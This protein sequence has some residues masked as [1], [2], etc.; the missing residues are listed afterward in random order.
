MLD[1]F[2]DFTAEDIGQP[3]MALQ[4]IFAAITERPPRAHAKDLVYGPN[5]IDTP[6]VGEGRT[7]RRAFAGMLRSRCPDVPLILEHLRPTDIARCKA[8][9]E[10]AFI[11]G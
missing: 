9:V 8:L 7:D 11:G 10:Q 1:P 2:N 6:K 4:R 3:R 5:G